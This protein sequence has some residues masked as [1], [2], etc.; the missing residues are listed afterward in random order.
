M[1]QLKSFF[2]TFSTYIE[3][4][5]ID[6]LYQCIKLFLNLD[7]KIGHKILVN[8]SLNL[9]LSSIKDLLEFGLIKKILNSN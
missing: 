6:N 7:S 1:S 2:S 9:L 3:Y 8:L 5:L 4:A